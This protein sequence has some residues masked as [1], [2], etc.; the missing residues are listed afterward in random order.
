[1][2]FFCKYYKKMTHFGSKIKFLD[3]KLFIIKNINKKTKFI[4]NNNSKNKRQFYNNK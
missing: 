2:S 4:K 3:P 1:M